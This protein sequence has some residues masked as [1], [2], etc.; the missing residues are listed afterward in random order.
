MATHALPHLQGNAPGIHVRMVN[1]QLKATAPIAPLHINRR[2]SDQW[3]WD[4]GCIIA[5][6]PTHPVSQK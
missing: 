5:F 4:V 6:Q 3:R 2:G 1:K